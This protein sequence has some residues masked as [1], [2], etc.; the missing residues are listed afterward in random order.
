[1]TKQQWTT[2]NSAY[3]GSMMTL[4]RSQLVNY[5]RYDAEFLCADTDMESG[6]STLANTVDNGTPNDISQPVPTLWIG[7]FAWH[8]GDFGHLRIASIQQTIVVE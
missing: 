6:L 8:V 4:T 7:W 3:D 2:W 5:I 1:M